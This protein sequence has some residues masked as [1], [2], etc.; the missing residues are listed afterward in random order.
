M[1]KT[2][3]PAKALLAALL[4]LAAL[5][6]GAQNGI[7]SPY[8]R[9]GVGVLSDQS[10]GRLKS[11]GGVGTGYRERNVIN[12]KNPA[13]YSMVDTLTFIADLGFSF[14]NTNF[15]ENGSKVNARNAGMD[16]MAMQFRVQPR[17]GMTIAFLPYSN[18]GYSFS[19]TSLINRDMDGEINANSSNAGTGGLRQ[20]MGGL[21]WRPTDWISIGANASYLKGDLSLKTMTSFSSSDVSSR[22]VTYESSLSALKADLGIQTTLK[23]GKSSDNRLVLGATWSHFDGMDDNT[24]KAD[25][26]TTGDTIRLEQAFAMPDEFSFGMSYSWK[27]RT[28]AADVTYENWSSARF[29]GREYGQDRFKASAGFRM[30][31]DEESKRFFRRSSYQAGLSFAQ[32]YFRADERKGP[33]QFGLTAGISMPIASAYNS[34]AYIHVTGGYFRVQPQESGMITENCLM[35]SVAVTFMERWFQKWLVE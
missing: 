9:Y 4:V 25:V 10:V 32:P 3:N 1:I 6:A 19:H 8:S 17:I 30:C 11:M 5:P 31:P 13:S 12:L 27:N 24:T 14:D 34:M 23:T 22:T 29:F 33:L 2:G 18:V 35:M 21:G 7:N 16:Y 26:H 15:Q 20:F 28:V